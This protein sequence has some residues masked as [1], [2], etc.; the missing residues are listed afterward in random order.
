MPVWRET[1]KVKGLAWKHNPMAYSP[2]EANTYSW[3]SVS[4][5]WLML[6][7]DTCW[8][9]ETI[10]W[11]CK[12]ATSI[13]LNSKTKKCTNKDFMTHHKR[14]W[15]FKVRAKVSESHNL[16]GPLASKKSRSPSQMVITQIQTCYSRHIFRVHAFP[17]LTVILQNRQSFICGMIQWCMCFFVFLSCAVNRFGELIRKIWNPRNFKAHV[18]PHEMLQVNITSLYYPFLLFWGAEI[19]CS[20][21]MQFSI[22]L[23]FA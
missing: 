19:H 16:L 2:Q 10:V 21:L 23:D 9:A 15:D 7:S 11:K 6:K 12:T 17:H 8:D 5:G 4:K 14:F 1:L 3:L 13:N 20:V 22:V 18:S